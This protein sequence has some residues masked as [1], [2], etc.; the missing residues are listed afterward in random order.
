MAQMAEK[1]TDLM[2]QERERLTKRRE[3]ILHELS[4]VDTELSRIAAYF[5]AGKTTRSGKGN[6]QQRGTV[7]T[8]VLEI[9]Q[10]IPNGIS[11]GDIIS[12]INSTGTKTSEQSI[13]NALSALKKS[14]KITSQDGKYK[15]A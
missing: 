15:T 13:S 4:E 2:Q 8:T 5:S 11:R 1:L 6:R 12:T 3:E 9:I 14:K 10:R 7:Q